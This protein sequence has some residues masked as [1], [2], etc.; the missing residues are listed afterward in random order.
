MPARQWLL[1]S[2]GIEPPGEGETSV[3]G[4]PRSRDARWTANLTAARQFHAREGHL[5][6]PRKAVENVAGE[7]I[8][9]G[10]FVDN[11]RRRAGKLSEQRRAELDG[12]GMRW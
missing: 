2:V 12:L 5:H 4:A 6:V 8:K 3:A 11:A 9:L 7:Q 1:E 10:A